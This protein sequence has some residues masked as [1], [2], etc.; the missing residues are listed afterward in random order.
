M[1]PAVIDHVVVVLLLAAAPF[2][3]WRSYRRLGRDSDPDARMSWYGWVIAQQWVAA[4][5]VLAVW[6]GLGR[7]LSLIGLGLPTSW[8][9]LLGLGITIA[10]L[11]VL[12]MQ[13]RSFGQARD[14]EIFVAFVHFVVQRR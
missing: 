14:G 1:N 4:L 7:P 3:A 13:W 9:S 2:E 8:Q 11:A 10:G 12:A 5:V 6:I